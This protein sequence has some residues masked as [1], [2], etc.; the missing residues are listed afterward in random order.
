MEQMKSATKRLPAAVVLIVMVLPGCD[1]VSWGGAQ[2]TIVPPPP[3]ATAP[4]AAPAD[5]DQIQ[6]PE[7]PVLFSVVRGEAGGVLTPIGEIRGDSLLPT[8]SD[9][10]ARA[11]ATQ[12]MAQQMRQGTEF[13]LYH[14]GQRAGTFVLRSARV[15]EADSCPLLPHALGTLELASGAQ[16]LPEFLALAK[17]GAPQL[18]RRPDSA[19][20]LSDRTMQLGA[21][22]LAEKLLRARHARLPSN[23]QRAMAQLQPFPVGNLQEPGFAA[24][25]LVDDTLGPGLDDE[26]ESLFFLG[27]PAVPYGYDTVYV[28]YRD[29]AAGG[30]EAPRVVDYL[31]WNHDDQVEL[32]LRVY[33][34]SDNWYEALGKGQDGRWRRIFR[35]RCPLPAPATADTMTTTPPVPAASR[36]DTSRQD[37]NQSG[38]T[39]DS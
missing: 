5:H 36:P 15:P 3:K 9:R 33:G 14:D 20:Q 19:L 28:H 4:A 22:I 35:D 29:Y 23:W 10:D 26:G 2:V 17:L 11:Y 31:D 8:H 18:P 32:L 12:L 21:P 7:G 27:V 37:T 39:E 16:Q 24:T 13:T 6:L 30:K 1:N 25:F 38:A 34:V